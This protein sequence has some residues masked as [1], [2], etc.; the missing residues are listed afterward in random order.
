MWLLAMVTRSTRASRS[1][2]KAAG[3]VGMWYVLGCGW[4]RLVTGVSRFT[5]VK[6]ADLSTE[7][8]GPN[9]VAGSFSSRATR[10]AKCTSPAKARVISLE[11]APGGRCL[12]NWLARSGAVSAARREGALDEQATVTII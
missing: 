2:V 7:V 6:S 10:P 4:P 9:V 11:A 1:A 8:M 5:A 3:G 12:T